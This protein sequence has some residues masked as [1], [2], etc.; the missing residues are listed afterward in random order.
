MRLSLSG[1]TG[2]IGATVLFEVIGKT[3]LMLKMGIRLEGGG[4][5]SKV[6]LQLEV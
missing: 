6:D 4:A 2:K 1:A 5:L 3:I